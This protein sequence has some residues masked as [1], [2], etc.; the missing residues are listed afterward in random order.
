MSPRSVLVILVSC[1]VVAGCTSGTGALGAGEDTTFDIQYTP[2]QGFEQTQSEESPPTTIYQAGDGDMII[3]S[4][5][6]HNQTPETF[7]SNETLRTTG[8]VYEEQ[9]GEGSVSGPFTRRFNGVRWLVMNITVAGGA[10]EAAVFATVDDARIHQ[11]SL[12]AA[13]DNIAERYSLFAASVR[14]AAIT[15]P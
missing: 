2:P 6:P 4:Q 5:V 13:G 8:G 1:I 14:N 10:Q 11:F 12:Y 15:R 9:N 7:F 3:Y